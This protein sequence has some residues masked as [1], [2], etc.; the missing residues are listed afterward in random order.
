[1]NQIINNTTK[2][3]INETIPL[4]HSVDASINHV[5]AARDLTFHIVLVPGAFTVQG[6]YIL[7]M[8]RRL[9]CSFRLVSN[10]CSPDENRRIKQ[11]CQTGKRLDLVVLPHDAMVDHGTALNTLQQMETSDYFCFMDADILASQNFLKELLPL[12]SGHAAVFSGRPLWQTQPETV[13]P[14]AQKRIMGRYLRTH[15]GVLLGG[16]YFAVYRNNLLKSI[17]R[18]YGICFHRLNWQDLPPRVSLLMVKMGLPAAYYDTGKIL[19]I[20]LREQGFDLAYHEPEGLLHIGGLSCN[21]AVASKTS[22]A[23]HHPPQA[24][25][26]KWQLSSHFLKWHRALV[27]GSPLPPTPS[28][29]EP[30]IMEKIERAKEQIRMDYHE[31]KRFC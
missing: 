27:S 14:A 15:S 4:K 24:T 17:V 2:R 16:S 18:E 1:M 11:F 3:R 9:P 30:E 5:P 26:L 21:V 10:G 28:I 19:N 6:C 25:R 20:L 7:G 12:M 13:L 31:F 22:P 29:E 23:P 8:L